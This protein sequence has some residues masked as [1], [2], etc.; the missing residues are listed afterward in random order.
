MFNDLFYF[1][2]DEFGVMGVSIMITVLG[3]I[4]GFEVYRL[5]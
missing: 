5:F 2:C 4:V 3:L 1:M